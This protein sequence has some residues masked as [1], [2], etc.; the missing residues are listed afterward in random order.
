[1]W[2]QVR[3]LIFDAPEAGRGFEHRLGEVERLMPP[4]ARAHP[5][6]ECI[7]ADHLRRELARVEGLGGEGLMFRQPG[8]PYEAGRSDT[9]L[10][11]KSFADAE[12]RV[13]GHEPGKG[14]H[15]GRLGALLIEL[16][17]GV[18]FA[19][20]TGLSDAERNSPP[21]VGSSITFR[22]Q[23]LTDGGVPRFPSYVGVRSI[24]QQTDPNLPSLQG[25]SAMAT[26][27]TP[28]RFTQVGGGSDKFWEI[29]VSGGKVTVCYG[30]NGTAGQS[31]TKSFADAAAAQKHADK[32][33]QEKTGKGYV[34]V[35]TGR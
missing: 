23:E 11:V 34:E 8:S 28:R 1:L 16:S 9:L 4:H 32:L 13:V 3:F 27:I 5:H 17:N 24:A 33:I 12:A 25:A 10:K 20:G 14:R 18:K 7:D 26:M 29:D 30:R 21:P 22:Y 15:K 35:R 31:I 2:N 6:L 19:V